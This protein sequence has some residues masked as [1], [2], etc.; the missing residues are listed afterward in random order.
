MEQN[1]YFLDIKRDFD[2]CQC[3]RWDDPMTMMTLDKIISEIKLGHISAND[4][5]L[6]AEDNLGQGDFAWAV[7]NMSGRACKSVM[8]TMVA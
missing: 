8:G 6:F 2:S 5:R 4:F 3:P 1:K 7:C